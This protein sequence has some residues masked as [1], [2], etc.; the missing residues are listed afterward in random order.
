MSQDSQKQCNNCFCLR[1]V[2]H[3][4]FIFYMMIGLGE[5]MA[6]DQMHK[7]QSCKRN[8]KNTFT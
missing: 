3:R 4:D 5:D 8:V 6:K 7:G 1:T 2:Y